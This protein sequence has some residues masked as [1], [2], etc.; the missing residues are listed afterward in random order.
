MRR[1]LAT[2]TLAAAVTT[3]LLP[4]TQADALYCGVL[5]PVCSVVC[6]V[7]GELGAYCVD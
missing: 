3:T 2:L 7:T 4:A 1:S 5:Q 6:R